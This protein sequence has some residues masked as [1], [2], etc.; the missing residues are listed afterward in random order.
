VIPMA[1]VVPL[2]PLNYL[3]G[4]VLGGCPRIA[5]F[6]E[7]EAYEKDYHRHMVDIPRIIF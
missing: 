2:I 7:I 1:E 5:I 6:S 3:A 4:P